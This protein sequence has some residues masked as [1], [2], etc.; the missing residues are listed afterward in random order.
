MMDH[1]FEATSVAISTDKRKND[2]MP[3]FDFR[4]H[5]FTAN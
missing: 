3:V 5:A 4:S 2:L 1:I